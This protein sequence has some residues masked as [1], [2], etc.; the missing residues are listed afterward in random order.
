MPA[1]DHTPDVAAYASDETGRALCLKAICDLSRPVPG[2]LYMSFGDR[3]GAHRV[4]HFRAEVEA[5]GWIAYTTE[6]GVRP[7]DQSG[8]FRLILPGIPPERGRMSDLA[9]IEFGDEPAD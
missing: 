2:T 3:S 8:P 9:W 7:S 4:S 5:L 1:A 6:D